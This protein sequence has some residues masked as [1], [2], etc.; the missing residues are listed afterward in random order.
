MSYHHILVPVDGSPTSLIAVNHAASLAKAFSSKVTLVYALTI[1][2]FISVEIIDSTEIAQDYF[3]K[4]RASI[5]SILDQAK[6]QFSQHG[7]SV[8]TKIVEGQTIHTEIIKAATELKADLL[9]IGSHGRKGFKKF[10]LGSVT[11][12]LLGEIHV[13]VLVVTE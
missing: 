9:V 11:Q 6:E 3:N 10:F 5:Q 13:P 8:E 2:P 4:A 1:D 12:T 7:I